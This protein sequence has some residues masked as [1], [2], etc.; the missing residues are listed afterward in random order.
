MEKKSDAKIKKNKKSADIYD[1]AIRITPLNIIYFTIGILALL[2][3]IIAWSIFGSIL[4][5]TRAFGILTTKLPIYSVNSDY[6]GLVSE[7]YKKRGDTV[8]IGD[9][10]IKLS[11]VD[12]GLEL[13]EQEFEL[14]QQLIL[15]SIQLKT[16][17]NE[18]RLQLNMISLEKSELRKNIK[19]TKDEIRFYTQLQDN[20]KI[21][22][23]KG[24][25]SQVQYNQNLF[26]LEKLKL[27]LKGDSVKLI[28]YSQS[29]KTTL[30]QIHLEQK[31]INANILDIKSKTKSLRVRYDTSSY[32][33]AS[34]N[35]IIQECLV[36]YGIPVEQ[37]DRVYTIREI[38]SVDSN[39]YADIFIPYFD[40][41]MAEVGMK[42]LISPYNVDQ[43]RF[44]KVEGK[45]IETSSYPATTQFL[46]SRISNQEVV[47]EV[48]K[49]GPVYYSRAILIRDTSTVSGYKWTSK[50][51][52][53]FS[54][55][56][57]MSSSVHIVITE[58]PPISFVIPWVKKQLR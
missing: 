45:L 15:D 20:S 14:Y 18:E 49:L 6:D 36:K 8:N 1:S 52:P 29:K 44:G 47:D 40:L 5:K 42:A 41:E 10:L 23:D 22:L 32:V 58:R 43:N 9:R 4:I 16:L 34:V 11:Q 26:Q 24:I 48:S 30:E 51:G 53:P 55:K 46:L 21:L 17:K 27:L 57:G 25:I 56:P 12:I 28:S 54:I 37:F 39:L 31:K 35:G 50:K 33:R 38:N 2:A 13:Q 3:V 19:Q 7:I